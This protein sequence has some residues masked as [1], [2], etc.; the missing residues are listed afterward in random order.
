MIVLSKATGAGDAERNWSDV[1]TVWRSK[2]K[3]GTAKMEK[4]AMIYAQAVEIR[5]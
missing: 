3:M 4:K 1:D 2:A 5:Y